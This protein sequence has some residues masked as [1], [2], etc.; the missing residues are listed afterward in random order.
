[1][2][3]DETNNSE[4][5]CEHLT[6]CVVWKK[7]NTNSKLFWINSYCKGPK[8][9]QCV[10]K[11]QKTKKEFIPDDLLPNGTYLNAD[12]NTAPESE[13]ENLKNCAI[14]K[15]FNTDSKMVWIK[16]YCQGPKQSKCVRKQ[17]AS[18]GENVPE[19]MLP[20]GETL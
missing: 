1:M 13:C 20:N 2:S 12:S 11:I 6:N 10:R 5:Q 3:E 17:L 14:W 16:A 7:F 19:N 8:E 18:Q 4:H 15:K 9:E